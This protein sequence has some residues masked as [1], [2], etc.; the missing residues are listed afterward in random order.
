M[1]PVLLAR[2]TE[3]IAAFYR[4]DDFVVEQVASFISEGLAANEH[5]IA[6]A[7][8]RHWNAIT[9]RLEESGIAY[10]RATSA[11]QLVFVEAVEA[12]DAV[13]V[14][15]EVSVDRFRA[16]LAPLVKPGTRTRIY[17]ELVSL[18]AQRGDVD[19]A[20][21]VERLGHEL[22][23]AQ[24][25]RVLCGYHVDGARPLT[26][27]EMAR[28][29]QTHDRSVLQ[30]RVTLGAEARP[31]KSEYGQLHAV[32]FYESRQSLAGM[33]G[34]FLGEGFVAGL[35]AVVIATPDHLDGIKGVLAARFFDV[36]RLAAAGDLIMADVEATLA[37][38][39]VDGMPDPARFGDAITPL[40]E[41]ACRGRKDCVIRAYGE[42]V[43]VLWKAG[44]TVAAVRLET[45]WNQLAQSHAFALLC[46]Y[47]MGHFY[48]DASHQEIC[49]LHTHVS[50][51][52]AAD[53]AAVH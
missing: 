6:V 19:A 45:L 53:S 29:Q 4:S 11:G 17:G 9:G 2:P 52:P 13:T 44:H 15:G 39:M 24:N 41:R 47:S 43:D 35:P 37:R 28:I 3:H 1:H 49:G 33:V 10:G 42:M 7:T 31:S 14:D 5:V 26:A 25:I 20:I 12:L 16:M 38:F 50:S 48:K 46:G 34:Q 27:D 8:I 18:L 32:R 23:H 30:D 36:A 51:D 40:I 22:A 21:A